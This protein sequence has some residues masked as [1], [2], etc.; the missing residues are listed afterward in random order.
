MVGWGG[1]WHN[2]TQMLSNLRKFFLKTLP[3]MV[4]VLGGIILFS[5][6]MD[7]VKDPALEALI[8]NISAS[9]LAIPLVFLLYDYTNT[10]V[11]RRLQ[12]TL[13]TG[14]QD[15]T[16][17]IVLHLILVLRRMVKM[18]GR[19]TRTNIGNLADLSERQILRRLNLRTDYVETLHQYYQDLENLVLGYGKENVFTPEQLRLLSDLARNI[20]H[21]ISVRHLGGN[22]RVIARHIKNI[23]NEI[24]DWL[25]SS[26]EV[27]ENFNQ[28]L[29]NA[30]SDKK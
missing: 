4:S 5:I 25:D 10:R 20:S 8:S 29:A 22:K 17:T 23:G 26:S 28:T 30:L 12:E 9:L 7:N 15:K 18:R 14:V 6:S 1:A 19:I 13:R 3:Y 27:S 11:S 2:T 24:S 16:N 21:I